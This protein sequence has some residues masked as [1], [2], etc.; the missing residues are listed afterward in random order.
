MDNGAVTVV[1]GIAALFLTLVGTFGAILKFMFNIR[2]QIMKELKELALHNAN[3][4][5]SHEKSMSDFKLMI[6]DTYGK[7]E[8]IVKLYERVNDLDTRIAKLEN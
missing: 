7:K 5:V 6:S 2:E 1:I 8:D 3:F 4:R